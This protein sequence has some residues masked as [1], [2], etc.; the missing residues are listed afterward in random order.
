LPGV[1]IERD[2]P[3]SIA[4]VIPPALSAGHEAHFPLVLDGLLQ[5]IDDGKWPAALAA[6]TL[7]KYALL[8]EAA[9]AVSPPSD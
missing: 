8:A 7:A 6:R 2:D 4:I 3:G 9:A 1:G 5:A